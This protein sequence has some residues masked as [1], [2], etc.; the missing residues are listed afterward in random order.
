MFKTSLLALIFTTTLIFQGCSD[1][2]KVEQANQMIASNEF[3]L[4]TTNGKQLVVRKSKDGFL[5]EGA[6]DKVIIFDIFATWCPPCRATAPHLAA[7]QKKYREDLVVIGMTIEDSISN[8][9]LNDFKRT[10]H[11]N[12]T[13]VN[14]SE[15]RKLINEIAQ[16]LELGARFPIPL[17]VMYKDGVKVEHYLGAVEEEFVDSDIKKALNK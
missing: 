1:N 14:S 4:T 13:L 2:D 15:N 16:Q 5:L 3:V 11:A 12:Y 9:K 17:M 8:E 6:R 7:L 10:Y